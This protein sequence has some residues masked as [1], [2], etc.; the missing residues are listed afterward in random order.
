MLKKREERDSAE[1]AFPDKTHGRNFKGT[2]SKSK[3]SSLINDGP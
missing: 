3:K 2:Q 1:T